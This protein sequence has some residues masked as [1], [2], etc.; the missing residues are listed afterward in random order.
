MWVWA[1][2]ALTALVLLLV[3]IVALS[4]FEGHR[5]LEEADGPWAYVAVFGLVFGDGVIPI[6]PGETTLNT[7]ATLAAQGLMELGWVMV[8]GAAGAVL[9]DSALYW[10]SRRTGDR[11]QAQLASAMAND[12]IATA[13]EVIGGSAG[14]LLV[15]GRYVP[16][17]RF[18]VNATL[19]L[20]RHPYSE[21]IRWS[22]VGGVAWS[23]YICG[24]AYAV[25]TVLVDTPFAAIVVSALAS[26]VAV[27]VVFVIVTRRVRRIRRESESSG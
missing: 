9:G 22:A 25:G 12:K 27:A 14:A 19:G 7:A 16:G 23:I 20:S 3:G 11:V 2:L 5:E 10:I 21:F 26:S 13:M 8:A 18:V 17:L 24:V 15:F 4:P 1:A 6:L